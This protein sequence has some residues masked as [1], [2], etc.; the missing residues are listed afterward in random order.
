[1]ILEHVAMLLLHS[2]RSQAYVQALLAA[3]LIPSAFLVMSEQGGAHH[4][5]G[6]GR[7]SERFDTSES[8]TD[9]LDRRGLPWTGVVATDA[10]DPTVR[11]ALSEL[12]APLIVYCGGGILRAPILS[13]GKRFLHVHPGT[14]PAFR[15][16][17]C[18]YY[19]ILETGR[20]GA[21]AFIMD[22]GIDTGA[23]VLQGSYQP[24]DGEDLDDVFDPW[25]RSHL[26]VRALCELS[27]GASP[28]I[29][30]QRTERGRTYYVIHPV[31]KA[32]ARRMCS[33]GADGR[34][35]AGVPSSEA[36]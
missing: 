22:E 18:F 2:R 3:D 19:E 24:R 25:M 27:P 28:S 1:M 8:V 30:P 20:C 12:R 15:G 13:M 34:I 33:H 35:L 11:Q 4:V 6:G 10:N 36:R 16:S 17:T 23:V 14:L 32:A 5:T 9:S 7:I 21:T 26:L 31:L 29:G